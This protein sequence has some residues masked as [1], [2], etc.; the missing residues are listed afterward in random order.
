MLDHS[1]TD[2]LRPQFVMTY[3]LYWRFRSAIG[4]CAHIQNVVVDGWPEFKEW[5]EGAV[6]FS[7]V[8]RSLVGTKPE[9]EGLKLLREVQTA[10]RAFH[11]NYHNGP[12][13]RVKVL[14]GLPKGPINLDT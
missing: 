10:V 3:K 5:H 1:K 11:M 13:G 8:F 14:A 9:T 12:L 2:D 6:E 4:H 7:R